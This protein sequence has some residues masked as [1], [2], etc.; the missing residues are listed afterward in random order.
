MENKIIKTVLISFI[1]GLGASFSFAGQTLDQASKAGGNASLTYDGS[2]SLPSGSPQIVN[3]SAAAQINSG[4][5][6]EPK[7]EEKEPGMFSKMGKDIKDNWAP[8]LVAGGAGAFAGWLL[9]GGLLGPIG[10]A[11]GVVAFIAFSRTNL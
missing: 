8:Y 2:R 6:I 1:M 9:F 5:L 11:L 4:R 3:P 7:K 10:M